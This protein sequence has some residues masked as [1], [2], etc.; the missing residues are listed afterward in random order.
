MSAA[1]LPFPVNKRGRLIES[2]AARALQLSPLAGERHI[3][4]QLRVQEQAM[5]RKGI[6]ADLV[7]H[8]LTSLECAIRI[9]LWES[10]FPQ[11]VKR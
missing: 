7:K 3:A 9:Q 4:Y 5:R 1:I 11:D 8:E 10:I 6:D 2:I